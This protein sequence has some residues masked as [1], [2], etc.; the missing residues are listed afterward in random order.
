MSPSAT[1]S[2]R[3]GIDIT[4]TTTTGAATKVHPTA[5]KTTARHLLALADAAAP[6]EE[7]EF[8]PHQDDGWRDADLPEFQFSDDLDDDDPARDLP[9]RPAPPRPKIRWWL[10]ASGRIHSAIVGAGSTSG[11]PLA[12]AALHEERLTALADVIGR[13]HQDAVRA[14]SLWD[15]L[16]VLEHVTATELL[17]RMDRSGTGDGANLSHLGRTVLQFPWG[18]TTLDTLTKLSARGKSKPMVRPVVEWA[19]LLAQHPDWLKTSRPRSVDAEMKRERSSIAGRHGVADNSLTKIQPYLIEI[20][21][22]PARVF[23]LQAAQPVRDWADAAA[24]LGNKPTEYI[25][26]MAVAGAFDDHLGRLFAD[27]IERGDQP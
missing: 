8:D 6:S 22:H 24:S 2:T 1:R 26:V 3:T 7:H 20:L 4:T 11:I 27:R 21:R 25:T 18:L 14:A 9:Q 15:A 19:G 10:D 23:A 13:D 16:L 12:S 17:A 5:D